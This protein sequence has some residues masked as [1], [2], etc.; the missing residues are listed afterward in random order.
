MLPAVGLF[1]ML[2]CW[3]LYSEIAEY[4]EAIRRHTAMLD[5]LAR[6]ARRE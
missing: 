3:A 6:R 1:S 4:R 5:E 2:V